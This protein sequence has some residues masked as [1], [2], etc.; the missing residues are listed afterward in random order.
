MPI[1]SRAGT[2]A[3]GIRALLTVA[4]FGAAS[5]AAAAP[6]GDPKGAPAP[7]C[8]PD[9]HTLCLDGGRFMVTA[10]FHLTPS[11]PDF[12]AHAVPSTDQTGDFWFFDAANIELIVKVLNGCSPPFNTYWVFAAGLTDVGV[13]ITVGDLKEQVTQRYTNEVGTAFLPIQDTNAFTTC[14]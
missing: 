6:A 11:G 1:R 7:L 9:D 5:V 13:V 2:R 3:S 8:T 4:L 12:A 14:P 10:A